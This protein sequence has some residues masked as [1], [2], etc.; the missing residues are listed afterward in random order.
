MIKINMK[1]PK[2]CEYCPCMQIAFESDLFAEGE[3][4]CCIK[5]ESVELNAETKRAKFCP[6]EEIK[7]ETK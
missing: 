7:E 3:K 2:K 5:A 6:L 4:Y 1:M